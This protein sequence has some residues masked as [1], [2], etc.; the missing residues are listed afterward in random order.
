[1][2][3]PRSP[4][5]FV[6]WFLVPLF[7]FCSLAGCTNP[8]LIR[9]EETRSLMDTFITVIVYSPNEA[10]ANEAID[11]AFARME[12]IEKI[13][14]IYDEE[15]EAFQLNQDGSLDAPSDDLI[16]LIDM[17]VEYG[18]LTGG[19]FD[20]TVQ[21]LLDLWQYN[22]DAEKQF[23]ELEESAQLEQINETFKLIGFDKITVED[24]SISFA[25]EG[26]KITLGGIAK[27]YAADEALVVLKNKG[28]RHALVDAGGDLATLGSKPGEEPWLISLINPD[29][30]SQSLATFLF[31][32]KSV[33]TSGNYERYFDPDKE[34]GHILDPKTGY[35][36]NECIS[37]TI[38]AE[39]CTQADILATA[40]FVMGSEDGLEFVESLD[41]VECLVV[42]S[43]RIINQS[44]GLS[45]YLE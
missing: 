31:S 41:G 44:S 6:V 24:D 9:Y 29:D 13:A 25:V 22:P 32:G 15:A 27:G 3:G 43:D 35:S 12:E 1:M 36:A 28:I 20:I 10:A 18:E 33:A 7:L 21:P 17:S 34:A 45:A 37:V 5:K 4:Y 40:V 11:A 16:K 30:T 39:N 42:D 2:S 23:W 38:I 19:C 14:S 8:P 26:M